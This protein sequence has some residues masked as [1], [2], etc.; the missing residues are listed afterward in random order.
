[1]RIQMDKLDHPTYLK[2]L[3]EWIA[4]NPTLVDQ[5]QKRTACTRR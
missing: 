4:E 2:I 1:M 3:T 5:L